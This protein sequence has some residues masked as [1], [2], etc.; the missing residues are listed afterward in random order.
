M[1]RVIHFALVLTLVLAAVSCEKK[2]IAALD[3]RITQLENEQIKTVADLK[4]AVNASISELQG[5][6][7]T[8]KGQIADL[9][10]AKEALDRTCAG[11]DHSIDSLGTVLSHADADLQENL[12]AL[13]TAFSNYKRDIDAAMGNLDTALDELRQKD[14]ALTVA[15]E[16]LRR[17]LT[18]ELAREKDR[19]DASY[20]SLQAFKSLSEK[21]DGLVSELSKLDVDGIYSRLDEWTATLAGFEAQFYAIISSLK[22]LQDL[23]T[24]LLGQIRSISFV[25][26]YSDGQ[27]AV[28][29]EKNEDLLSKSDEITFRI[30]PASAITQIKEYYEKGYVTDGMP[31]LQATAVKTKTRSEVELIPLPISLAMFDLDQG[32]MHVT[33]DCTPLGID[34]PARAAIAVTDGTR[35]ICSDYVPLFSAD[36]IIQYSTYDSRI[37]TPSS[38]QDKVLH[39]SYHGKKGGTI[40]FDSSYKAEDV[41]LYQ[42]PFS[43]T[44]L[45]SAVVRDPGFLCDGCF[46]SCQNLFSVTLPE[47]LETIPPLAFNNCP[48]LENL[49]LPEGLT[50]IG[51][52]AFR[53]CRG[54]TFKKWP[55]S[56]RTIRDYAF[57]DCTGLEGELN[58]PG[59]EEIG[60]R[61]FYNCPGLTKVTGNFV[62]TLGSE[63]FSKDESIT[64]IYFSHLQHLGIGAFSYCKSLQYVNLGT[65]LSIIPKSAFLQCTGLINFVI[66]TSVKTVEAKAFQGCSGI[67]D[68]LFEA[69]D[70]SV[71]KIG[72]SAFA[73]CSIGSLSIN[74]ASIDEHAFEDNPIAELTLG[75]R[76][77]WIGDGAFAQEACDTRVTILAQNPPLIG[78]GVWT[79]KALV[80]ISAPDPDTYKAAPGWSVYA[81][82][83]QPIK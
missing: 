56:L 7:Q 41:T 60:S 39:N 59:V 18:E 61:A 44:N 48:A 52:Q 51:M 68:L 57:S 30:S 75:S 69:S 28:H 78:A 71:D 83:I 77:A 5:M 82:K 27:V 64:A 33:L 29:F 74:A 10:K 36:Y 47:G 34:Y 46:D 37:V 8:L 17:F 40:I 81:D 19:A 2:D 72:T 3:E 11:L 16:D 76:T 67:K 66:P 79:D 24:E 73:G 1:K 31:F 4:A 53:D 15:I 63:A 65:N 14:S 25:P 45:V 55:T 42:G 62:R 80:S 12:S 38:F 58:L 20:A 70:H 49:L 9:V 22:E 23:V 35:E 6:D 50:E 13:S 21:V 43:R 32:L 26:E 54:L